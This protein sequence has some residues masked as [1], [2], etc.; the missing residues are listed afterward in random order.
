[1]I[2]R[3]MR[4]GGGGVKDRLELFRKFIRFGRERRPLEVEEKDK[5]E[6][7]EEGRR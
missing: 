1:M 6:G 3:K 4:G 7:E 5:G 2:F